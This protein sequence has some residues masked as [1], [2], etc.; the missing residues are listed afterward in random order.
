MKIFHSATARPSKKEGP[1]EKLSNREILTLILKENDAFEEVKNVYGYLYPFFILSLIFGP[2]YSIYHSIKHHE[3][4]SGFFYN[5]IASWL[6]CVQLFSIYIQFIA[7]IT[8]PCITFEFVKHKIYIN[9]GLHLRPRHPGVYLELPRRFEDKTW[10]RYYVALIP[11]IILAAVILLIL[12]L[13][14]FDAVWKIPEI[15]WRIRRMDSIFF[16]SD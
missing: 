7:F 3:S 1:A 11:S 13:L 4:I 9:K 16:R 5:V 8:I 15:G 6:V 2:I 14:F 10:W 12:Y